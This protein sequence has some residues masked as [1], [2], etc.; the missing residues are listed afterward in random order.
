MFTLTALSPLVAREHSD[1]A[2]LRE[3]R[4][5]LRL[6]LDVMLIVS[7]DAAERRELLQHVAS[8]P[9]DLQLMWTE[10][11][12]ASLLRAS[13]APRRG[14]C[15]CPIASG[16][17]VSL[18]V[19]D[20]SVASGACVQC[21]HEQV[22]WPDADASVSVRA[23]RAMRHQTM[24]AGLARDDAFDQYIAP[25]LVGAA[26]LTLIDR[27]AGKTALADGGS[28]TL[29]WL[30]TRVWHLSEMRVVLVTGTS[31]L[32]R[33]RYSRTDVVS[34]CRRIANSVR[35]PMGVAAKLSLWTADDRIFMRHSHDRFIGVTHGGRELAMSLGKGIEVFAAPRTR[36]A[37]AVQLLIDDNVIGRLKASLGFDSQSLRD[38]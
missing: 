11:V 15:T 7:A 38:V 10:V 31:N 12:R 27:Y 8:L 34:A 32:A 26:E 9:P 13:S 22:V 18:H 19:H 28:G 35:T 24:P 29:A 25:L 21:G 36:Q 16:V 30:L 5:F 23:V 14:D 3:A 2:H 17:P 33:S 6:V 20:T 4:H 37:S 1:P